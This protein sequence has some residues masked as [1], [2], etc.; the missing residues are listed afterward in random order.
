VTVYWSTF[1]ASDFQLDDAE[2]D[3]PPV[4]CTPTLESILNGLEDQL[5]LSEDEISNSMAPATEVSSQVCSNMT[6]QEM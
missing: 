6:L 3:I 5:S 2:Y 1:H 4:D